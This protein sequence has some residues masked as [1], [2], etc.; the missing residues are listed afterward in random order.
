MDRGVESWEG[1]VVVGAV[2]DNVRAS[3]WLPGREL[4]SGQVT[5]HVR[6]STP[7]P[8]ELTNSPELQRVFSTRRP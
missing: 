4:P 6:L 3:G 1:F 7:Q 8:L 2:V 5:R